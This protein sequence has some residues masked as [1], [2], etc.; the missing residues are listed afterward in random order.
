MGSKRKRQANV[1]VPGELRWQP[2]GTSGQSWSLVRFLGPNAG[3]AAFGSEA[4]SI[5]G[6]SWF[7]GGPQYRACT[8]GASWLLRS[9]GPTFGRLWWPVAYEEPFLP[10][11]YARSVWFEPF[12]LD[13]VFSWFQ[14]LPVANQNGDTIII[15][16]RLLMDSSDRV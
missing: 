5:F 3:K 16:I 1:C 9:T 4:P 7:L 6:I 12:F 2:T 13:C 14:T 8:C 10:W 15:D 11:I